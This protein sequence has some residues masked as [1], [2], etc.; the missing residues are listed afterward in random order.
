MF[1]MLSVFADFERAMIVER[2]KAGMA[3]ARAEGK[4]IGRPKLASGVEDAVRASLVSGMG[5]CRAAKVHGCGVGTVQ[6]IKR[7]HMVGSEMR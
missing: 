7:A 5:I 6:R 3:R 4:V 1:G 2:T